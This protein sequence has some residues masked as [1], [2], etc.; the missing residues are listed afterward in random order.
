MQYIYEAVPSTFMILTSSCISRPVVEM[1]ARY[2][3]FIPHPCPRCSSTLHWQGLAH[4]LWMF[5][6]LLV[7]PC[8]V[9]APCL[10]SGVTCLL[11]LPRETV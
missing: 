4:P 7:L 9:I 3:S 11:L 2:L 10:A 8:A 1:C 6:G 5:P